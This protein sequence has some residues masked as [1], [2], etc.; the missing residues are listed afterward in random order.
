MAELV[1]VYEEL[2]ERFARVPAWRAALA[3]LH[4]RRGALGEA[5]QELQRLADD[6]FGA[7]PRDVVW[8]NAMTYL[9][10]V[11]A[12]V[13]APQTASVAYELLAPRAGRIAV[14]DRGFVCKGAADMQLGLLASVIGR[15]DLALR[16]LDA[17]RERREKMGARPLL[18]RA[19][20]ARAAVL[21]A[22]R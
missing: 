20:L 9:A 2:A 7:I 10:E 4:T 1:P 22:A 13:D 15:H 11:C 5:E 8:V 18:M 3:M 19:A 14:I 6:R 17:A 12:A 16:H 21:E